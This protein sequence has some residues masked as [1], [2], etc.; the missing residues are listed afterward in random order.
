MGLFKDEP[1]S[2]DKINGLR[3]RSG[4]HF[5]RHLTPWSVGGN[6]GNQSPVEPF[7]WKDL[8]P[9]ESQWSGKEGA[10]FLLRNGIITDSATDV[11]RITQLFTKTTRGKLFIAKQNLLSRSGVATEASG[12]LNEG[13]LLYTSPSPRDLSTSRMPSSA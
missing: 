8:P 2:W 10:D 9:L 1:V 12:I 13:C 3:D 7:I 5:Q 11:S 6:I 4:N